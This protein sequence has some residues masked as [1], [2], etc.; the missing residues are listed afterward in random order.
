M[1]LNFLFLGACSYSNKEDQ[2]PLARKLS[3]FSYLAS[4]DIREKCGKT[5]VSQF[6]FVYNGMY[7]EQVRAY[8]L[9]P[10]H[11]DLA[12]LKIK[13]TQKADLSFL[14][15]DTKKMDFLKPWKPIQSNTDIRKIDVELL[16]KSLERVAFL[17]PSKSV[18]RLPSKD[19]YWLVTAC[20]RGVFSQRAY[21]WPQ[22]KFE[23]LDF[24][25]LLKSW[26][27]SS[28]PYNPTRKTDLFNIYGTKDEK[29]YSNNFNFILDKGTLLIGTP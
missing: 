24:I 12:R 25:S 19:F 1:L 10:I 7:L 3:W 18:T 6:R 9:G 22:Y 23:D 20:V 8:D 17:S 11:G 2:S 15:M 14:E 5:G 28:I 27:F 21:L 29:K 26:D 4:N 16:I 13:I